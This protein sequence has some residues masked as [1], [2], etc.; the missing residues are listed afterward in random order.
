MFGFVRHPRFLK[1]WPKPPV[2]IAIRKS[3]LQ[4]FWHCFLTDFR[5]HHIFI[6]YIYIF[7]SFNSFRLPSLIFLLPSTPKPQGNT[8][9]R[10]VSHSKKTI[11]GP[12]SPSTKAWWV[13]WPQAVHPRW[14]SRSRCQRRGRES[15]GP[16]RGSAR[17]F[18]AKRAYLTGLV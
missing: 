5:V 12:C 17:S 7:S 16:P 18:P 8:H 10:V 2:T 14:D 4:L 1:T 13:A 15:S 9:S 3:P 6:L 11:H